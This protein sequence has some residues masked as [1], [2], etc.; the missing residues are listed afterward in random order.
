MAELV[1]DR[2]NMTHALQEVANAINHVTAG[3]PF[4]ALQTGITKGSKRARFKP[5]NFNETGVPPLH[6]FIKFLGRVR[7]SDREARDIQRWAG[8]NAPVIE[9]GMTVTPSD[10]FQYVDMNTIN[11]GSSTNHSDDVVSLV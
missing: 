7:F 9:P 3:G 2:E 1:P 6:T 4:L 10:I 5:P 8:I 11:M